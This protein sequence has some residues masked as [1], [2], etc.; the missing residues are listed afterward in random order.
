MEA[1]VS[2]RAWPVADEAFALVFAPGTR[3]DLATIRR[4]VEEGGNDGLVARLSHEPPAE[5]GWVEILASGLTFDLRGLAPAEAG[6]LPASSQRYGFAPAGKDA[7]TM[8]GEAVILGPAGHIAAGAGLAPV[9]RTM[10]GLAANLALH[11]PLREV[12]WPPARSAMEPAYFARLVLNWLAGGAFPALGLT[13]LARAPDGSVASEGLAFFTGAEMQL[14]AGPKGDPVA[15]IKL[16]VRLVDYLVANG[17]PPGEVDV[18]IGG[19][20]LVLEPAGQG[21]KIWAWRSE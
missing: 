12:L 6:P 9:I 21:R 10:A 4:I 7:P 2:T 18:S 1:S 14:E 5:E 19:E 8:P 3:P 13:S 16:A 17:V 15:D 11:L 20:Q